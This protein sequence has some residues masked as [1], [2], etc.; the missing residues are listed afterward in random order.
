MNNFPFTTTT[1]GV[2]FTMTGTPN[3][4]VFFE[5]STKRPLA[6]ACGGFEGFLSCALEPGKR[7]RE[8]GGGKLLAHTGASFLQNPA[9]VKRVFNFIKSTIMAFSDETKRSAF[10]Y[11]GGKCE[12]TRKEHDHI[13]RCNAPLTMATAEF[14]HITAESV[15]GSDGLSNCE[16]LCHECHVGTDSYGRS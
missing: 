4:G 1:N 11:A 9:C 15:G 3:W 2:W 14:H 13:G 10:K 16:V 8:T 5:I 6:L 12:C 7:R